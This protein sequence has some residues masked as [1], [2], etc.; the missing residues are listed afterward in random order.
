MIQF[1]DVVLGAVTHCIEYT[2]RNNKGQHKV[3]EII[4]PLVKRMLENPKNKN[5]QFGYYRKYSIS[6]FPSVKIY[7]DNYPRLDGLM[8]SNR[9][10]KIL[11][12]LSSQMKLF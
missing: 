9:N 11:D 10:L 8:Y 4:V 12:V 3:S 6:F 7:K 2:N 1:V 5:S